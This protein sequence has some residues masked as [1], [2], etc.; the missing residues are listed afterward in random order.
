M[1]IIKFFLQF[2]MAVPKKKT[3]ASKKGMR[4]SH[5]ALS[6]INIFEA[7]NGDLKLP[8]HIDMKTGVY[9]DGV[10]I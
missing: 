8:H 2:F 7:K 5:I 1:P 10:S 9:R 6:K 3:S 4:R